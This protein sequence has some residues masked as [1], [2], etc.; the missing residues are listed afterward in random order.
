MSLLRSNILKYYEQNKPFDKYEYTTDFS[1]EKDAELKKI[2][3]QKEERARQKEE[4]AK[5]K[6]ED[7]EKSEKQEEPKKQEKPKITP[8]QE[9]MNKITIEMEQML[10]VARKK[11]DDI[12]KKALEQAESIKQETFKS[13][14]KEGYDF[15]YELGYKEAYEENEEKLKTETKHFL[16]NLQTVIKNVE[17]EKKD[18]IKKYCNDL[19]NIAI[20]IGEKV[21]QISLKSSGQII[22]KMI[23][24]ATE[25]I[26]GKE[27]AKIYIA[28]C[29]AEL[30]VEGDIDIMESVS[31]I[32]ENLKVIALDNENPGTCIVE[33]PDEIIDASVNTQIENI[34]GILRNTSI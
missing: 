33:L 2:A 21:I 5:L 7:K 24:S 11:A 26:S 9:A 30:M 13:A 16:D 32:S 18:I 1:A 22:E 15:G 4:K 28:R 14:Q 25:K 23:I 34:K 8:E 17:E 12:V 19:K 10:D 29:D 20:A 31:H 27:W 3:K 6:K